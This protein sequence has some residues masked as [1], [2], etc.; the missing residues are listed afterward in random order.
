MRAGAARK[1]EAF[2]GREL[3][4]RTVGIVGLGRWAKVLTRAV[5]GKSNKLEIVAGYSRSQVKRD[6]FEK[7]F[8]V[9]GVPDMRGTTWCIG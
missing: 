8:G 2:M 6:E 5:H 3:I 9:P 1:R 7:E 4:G